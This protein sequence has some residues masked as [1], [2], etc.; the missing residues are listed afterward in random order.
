MSKRPTGSKLG[1]VDKPT[2]GVATTA[3]RALQISF[4]QNLRLARINAGLTQR[5]IEARTGIKQAYVS[6]IE[7]GK[8]NPTLATMVAL[9][10]VVGKNVREL[11][12]PPPSKQK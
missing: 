3:V 4:G 2:T 5:D 7:A 11:L 8:L 10:D 9:A 1:S 6:Q 12:R